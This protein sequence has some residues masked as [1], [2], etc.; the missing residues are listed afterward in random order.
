MIVPS[1]ESSRM[2]CVLNTGKNIL[3]VRFIHLINIYSSLTIRNT[4]CQVLRWMQ[5][6]WDD[7]PGHEGVCGLVRDGDMMWPSDRREEAFGTVLHLSQP[8]QGLKQPDVLDTA[9]SQFWIKKTKQ[10]NKRPSSVAHICSPSNWRQRSRGLW[11]KASL[12]KKVSE[13]SHLLGKKRK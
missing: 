3:E 6:N 12:G 11:F 8:M 13:T 4:L 9:P 2:H 5:T 10:Q 1:R 7:M